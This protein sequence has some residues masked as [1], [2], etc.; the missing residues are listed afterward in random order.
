MINAG[1]N[2]IKEHVLANTSPDTKNLFKETD[3]SVLMFIPT[4]AVYIYIAG[5]KKNEPVPNFFK[6]ETREL[7]LNSRQEFE[8]QDQAVKTA[9]EQLMTDL[10]NF[11]TQSENDAVRSAFVKLKKIASSELQGSL[12]ATR[13]WEKAAEEL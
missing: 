7:I 3:P 2:F 6:A 9:L 10:N 8:N 5:A 12:F 11:D 1:A 4:K 13:C